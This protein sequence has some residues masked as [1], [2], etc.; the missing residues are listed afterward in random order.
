[1]KLSLGSGDVQVAT[2]RKMIFQVATLAGVEKR[3]LHVALLACLPTRAAR[4]VQNLAKFQSSVHIHASSRVMQ[5]LVHHAVIWVQSRAAS[6]ARIP[7]PGAVLRLTT[8]L[9]GVVLRYAE[10]SCL[11]ASTPAQNHVM[12]AYVVLVKSLWTGFAIVVKLKGQSV[13]TRRRVRSPVRKLNLLK[14]DLLL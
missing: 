14:M 6:A 4:L 9:A 12:K 8:K 10:I 11:V 13:A 7:P 1:V 2:Y 5:G 3:A